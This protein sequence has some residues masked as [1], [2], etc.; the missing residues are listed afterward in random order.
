M[1]WKERRR[2]GVAVH[3]FD[4]QSI[5]C[6][7]V[8]WRPAVCL[9]AG[10]ARCCC[11]V[12]VCCEKATNSLKYMLFILHM[13][14]YVVYFYLIKEGKCSWTYMIYVTFYFWYIFIL[15]FWWRGEGQFYSIL[16]SLFL[17]FYLHL[18]FVGSVPP[19]FASF[20]SWNKIIFYIYW[21]TLFLLL[22]L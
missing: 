18:P 4:L 15:V 1:I 8:A 13:Y 16:F 9:R 3:W 19:P 21:R 5:D 10:Y 20:I 7:G 22:L 11:A 2:K 12:Y 6:G 17:F 14:M